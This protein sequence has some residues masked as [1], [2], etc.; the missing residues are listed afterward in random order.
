MMPLSVR[1]AWKGVS[2][3]DYREACAVED[4]LGSLARPWGDVLVLGD[5]PLR[6]DGPCLIRWM[7]A[8]DKKRLLEVALEARFDGLAPTET[9]K[10]DVRDEPYALF[11]GGADGLTA[12]LL[13]FMPPAGPRL[14]RTDVV[15]DDAAGVGLILHR[16]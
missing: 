15:R 10:V 14:I 16:F 3:E 6:P 8:P 13:E 1:A 2:G 9:L 5:E 11:D 7:Y 4:S 12:G